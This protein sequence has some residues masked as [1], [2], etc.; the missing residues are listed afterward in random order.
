MPLDATKEATANAV[1]ATKEVAADAVDATGKAVENAGEAMQDAQELIGR[2]AH[3]GS[4]K[5]G[6]VRARL[7]CFTAR[8]LEVHPQA[9]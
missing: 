9:R 7:F 5:A 6:S 2:S 8:R 3:A 1:D 4:D